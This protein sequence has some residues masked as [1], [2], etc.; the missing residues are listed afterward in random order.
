[1]LLALT[2]LSMSAIASRVR[3]SRHCILDRCSAASVHV[4]SSARALKKAFRAFSLQGQEKRKQLRV[5]MVTL[6][7]RKDIIV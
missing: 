2:T 1:M 3:P 5:S 7:D 6:V 4:G